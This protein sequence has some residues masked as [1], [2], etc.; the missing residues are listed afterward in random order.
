[1]PAVYVETREV[2]L[3]ELA[4]FPGNAKRGDV[5][6]IRKSLRRNGQYRSLVVRQVENGPLVVLAGNHTMRALSAEGAG[7][8]RCEIVECDDAEARRINLADNRLADIGTYDNDALTELLSYLD[9]DYEGS[10]YTEADI[11]AL[12]EPPQ[13]LPEEGDAPIDAHD[14]MWGVVVTCRQEQEQSDLLQRLDSE[15]YAVRAL[16]G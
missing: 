15:G 12:I 10:G 11:D 8:A 6:G 16:L 1:M 4:P 13:Q 9:G 3:D 14:A 5:E 2:P 7:T